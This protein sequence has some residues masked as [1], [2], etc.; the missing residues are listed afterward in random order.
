M[1]VVDVRNDH[2]T[3]SLSGWE[4]VGALRRS[5]VSVPL[6]SISSVT[7]LTNARNGIR[8]MRAPGTGLPGVIALGSWRTRKTVDFVA[9]SR[10]EPGYSIELEGERFDRVVVSS[11]MVA[12]LD[13]LI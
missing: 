11:P 2:L 5:D 4:K 7:K 13:T 9:V 6:S 10:N 1:A 8:G 3:V 12:E